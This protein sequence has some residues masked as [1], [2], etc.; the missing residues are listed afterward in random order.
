MTDFGL[1]LVYYACR[2]FSFTLVSV[3][4]VSRSYGIWTGA[5]G[6]RA[7]RGVMSYTGPSCVAIFCLRRSK[8]FLWQIV[9]RMTMGRES[10]IAPA[11]VPRTIV[12]VFEMGLK[13]VLVW[14][15][16]L[17]FWDIVGRFRFCSL[18]VGSVML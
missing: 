15:V 7:A 1:A 11:R 5:G 18:W 9:Q 6:R 13:M 8:H 4:H 17:P 2:G 16:T 10:A 3:F 12:A 14:G